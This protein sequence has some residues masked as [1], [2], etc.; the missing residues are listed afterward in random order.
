MN[1]ANPEKHIQSTRVL[2]TGGN[3]FF[4]RHV[5]GLLRDKGYDVVAP[6]KSDFDLLNPDS[7]WKMFMNLRPEVVVHM[8]AICGGIGANAK[9]PGRFFYE[10]MLM[11]V[12]ILH[13]SYQHG[14]EKFLG[15]GT[16]CAY[17]K[18]TSVPFKEEDLWNG[19]PE[20]TNAP[21]GIAKKAL[22]VMADAYSRQY[23]M[24]A[25]TLLPVNLYGPGDSLDLERNHVIPA[26]IKKFVDAKQNND[27][28][29]TVWGTGE[30]SREFLYVEDAAEGLVLALENYNNPEPVNLGAGFEITIKKLVEL[31]KSET[32]Y[33]GEVIWDTSRPD[34]QPRRC[35][36]VTKAKQLFGFQARTSFGAGIHQTIAWYKR[37]KGIL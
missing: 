3:G 10:N 37:V 12:N 15:V 17:P 25:V 11:G 27:P 6:R 26:L 24:N 28:S 31:I 35:L 5:V 21:Y 29:V 19:Y 4:G 30:V 22:M 13:A 34:G 8:A 36:D 18:M 32:G 20:E 2:V 16:I 1:P 7:C 14:V 23:K 33:E 9:E